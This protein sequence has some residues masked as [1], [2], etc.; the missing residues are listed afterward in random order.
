MIKTLG[1]CVK[2]VGRTGD[3][4]FADLDWRGLARLRRAIFL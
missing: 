3:G 1:T 4:A 2:P